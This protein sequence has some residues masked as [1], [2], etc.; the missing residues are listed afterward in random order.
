MICINNHKLL[1][2]I[3][4]IKYQYQDQDQINQVLLFH[5]ILHIDPCHLQ[6]KDIIIK[7]NKYNNLN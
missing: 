2:K 6:H 3:I 5:K 1:D 7:I 4:L